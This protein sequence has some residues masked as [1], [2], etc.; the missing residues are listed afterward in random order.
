M[1]LVPMRRLT[2]RDPL[3]QLQQDVNELFDRVFRGWGV[4]DRVDAPSLLAPAMDFEEDD[5]QYYVHMD[6]PGVNIADVSVEVANGSLLISGEKRAEREQNGRHSHTRERYYGRF[7]RE[8]ALPQ[9][10]DVEHLKAELK[11]GVLTVTIPKNGSAVRR[12]IPI[13]GE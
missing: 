12:A 1:G 8:V 13:E 7:S 5:R 6:V 3:V 2:A 10:A 4:A 11:R 9:D